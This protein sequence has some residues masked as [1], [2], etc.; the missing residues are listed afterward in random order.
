MEA[1]MA[2]SSVGRREFISLLGGAIA[3]W[4]RA[5]RAQAAPVI[6]FLNS[7]SPDPTLQRVAAFREGL[8]EVGYVGGQNVAIEFRWA[9]NQSYRLQSL[10]ADLVRRRV[11]VIAATGG[12]SAALAAKHATSTI[13][14]VFEIGGDPMA[15]GLIADLNGS[16]GNLTGI[17][18]NI[19]ALAQSQLELLRSFIPK[20]SLVAMF[21]NPD[22]PNSGAQQA[23]VEAA[24]R[25]LGMQTLVLYVNKETGFDQPFLSLVQ[26]RAHALLV[27]SDSFFLEWRR[28]IVALAALHSVPTIYPLR[29]YAA[30][31]GLMSYGVSI[32]EGYHQVGVYVGRI[33]K[34]EKPGDLPIVNA[35]KFKL[36]IN[37]TTARTLGLD[38]PSSLLASADEVIQ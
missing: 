16:R 36:A 30:D 31:G 23:R 27:S 38:L 5:A 3:A 9:E 26:R 35:I 20:A 28:E 10:A 34:G 17:S 18:L 25:A 22:N 12:T 1:D 32:I 15:T 19:G 11:A 7:T 21:V 33:L 8:R 37:V 24:A 13:P 29:A 2:N 14:I 6:G 4:P